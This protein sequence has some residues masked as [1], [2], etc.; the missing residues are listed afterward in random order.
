MKEKVINFLKENGY[1]QYENTLTKISFQKT[2]NN[3]I[4]CD[5]NKKLFINIHYHDI[6]AQFPKILDLHNTIGVEI[7]AEKHTDWYKLQCCSISENEILLKLPKIESNLLRAFEAIHKS[8]QKR[9]K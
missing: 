8:K 1:R 5:L 6:K 3:K 2:V 9:N 4:V 7:F